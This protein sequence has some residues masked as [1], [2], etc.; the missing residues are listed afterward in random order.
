[1]IGYLEGTVQG[2]VLLTTA[3]VGYLVQTPSPL[4][5]GHSV[6]LFVSTVVREDAITLY[7][8]VDEGEQRLFD[9]LCRVNGVGAA[10]ALAVLRD[11]GATA[12]VNAVTSLDPSK[13]GRVKGVGPKT[14][15]RIVSDLRIPDGLDIVV[16]APAVDSE[17]VATLVALGFDRAAAIEAIASA[18]A[19][20][21]E[22]VI[23]AALAGMRAGAR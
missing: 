22:S 23:A 19:G 7:G 16:E 17:L 11:A 3:G 20:D 2:R 8:F 21:E 5:Q 6:R 1:M 14:A 10:S 15:A 18:P 12:V 4:P 9:A 13:L